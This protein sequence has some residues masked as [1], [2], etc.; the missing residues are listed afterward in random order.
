MA[1]S[2]VAQLPLE[3]LLVVLAMPPLLV[4][5]L[6]GVAPSSLALPP[7]TMEP[8]LRLAPLALALLLGMEATLMLV[9]LLA[10]APL[11]AAPL[12]VLHLAPLTMAPRLRLA[13]MALAALL[14][15]DA[16]LMTLSLLAVAPLVVAQ[17]LAMA[18]RSLTMAPR[19][20]L[21]PLAVAALM[22]PLLATA[23]HPMPRLRVCA[24]GREDYHTCLV[25][26]SQCKGCSSIDARVL[27]FQLRDLYWMTVL[28]CP[29]QSNHS[30]F[31]SLYVVCA[32]S[33][34][35]SPARL[36]F[37]LDGAVL[38][39]FVRVKMVLCWRWMTPSPATARARDCGMAPCWCWPS[40]RATHH[41][42]SLMYV[43]VCVWERN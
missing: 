19:L 1:S 11:A 29:T 3:G 21:A 30:C 23:K 33:A 26:T 20:R 41:T 38:V 5:A 9:P 17:L 28:S 27:L 35:R 42:R 24:L 32:P 16:L 37:V 10:L 25:S 7:N 40:D 14:V 8:R 2:T 18:L 43:Y 15:L 36:S 34:I 4:L 13:Q 6:L 39:C 31:F 22:A 12:L